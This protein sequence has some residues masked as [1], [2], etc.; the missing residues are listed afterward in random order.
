MKLLPGFRNSSSDRAGA[1]CEAF[2]AR[3]SRNRIRQNAVVRD[4]RSAFWRTQLLWIVASVA[5]GLIL[6]CSLVTAGVSTNSVAA[7]L[8]ADFLRGV[9]YAHVHRRGHGYG[10]ETSAKELQ[11]LRKLGVNRIALTPF[12][13]QHSAKS[14]WIAEATADRSMTDEDIE[15]EIAAAAK[16]GIRSMIKPHIWA[17]DFWNGNEWHAT[18]QQSSPEAHARWWAS[19]REMILHY[20]CVAQ[21]A[22]AESLCVGT[23]LVEMT[24]RFPSEWRGL[25]ADVRK[26]FKGKLTYA[27]HWE[28]EFEEITFWN[29]LDFIGITAYFP[30]AAPEG[31]SIEQL[32]DAWR[33]HRERI[34]KVQNQ[35]HKPVVFLEIGYRPVTETHIQPWL[36]DGGTPN[37]A[38]QARAFEAMF[39]ALA[40]ENWFKGIYIW[41]TFTDP[42]APRRGMERADFGFRGLPAEEVIARWFRGSTQ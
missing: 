26:V 2:R 15:R 1:P 32:T 5:L 20:A 4:G 27:G 42:E 3:G 36:Y 24:H 29:D 11:V 13:Y 30:L 10:S 18:V 12:G 19:Y 9:N 28:R 37:A 17:N 25:I 6:A 35:Y 38:A 22:D 14:D 40:G 21:D 41:K 23:E 39:R 34:A 7:G 33:P 31:A 16:L 8:P